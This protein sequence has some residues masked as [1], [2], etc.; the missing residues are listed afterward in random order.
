MDLSKIGL[1]IKELRKENK[2]S[3]Q[4]LADM[5]PIDRT[6]L[7]KWENGETI[8]P[9]DK[10]IKI[11]EIFKISID[12][13]ISGE[14]S[15]KE[16]INI[17]RNNLFD[18]LISQDS[19]Y[20]KIKKILFSTLIIIF[21]LIVIFLIYYFNQTYNT[22]KIFK[23]NTSSENYVV[24]NG[25]L[26]I[27]RE[28]SY[29]KIGA[30]NNEILNITIY[31]KK[32]G[33]NIVMFEGSS[34]SLIT[35]FNGYNGFINNKNIDKIKDNLYLKINEDE[36]KLYLT[37]YYNNDDLILKTWVANPDSQNSEITKINNKIP[38]KIKK[39]FKC[40]KLTCTKIIDDIQVD[41]FTENN[42]IF[43][44][45]KDNNVQYDITYNKLYF[46]N[47]NINFIVDNDEFICKSNSCIGYEKLYK[48][49]YINI[50]K[51]YI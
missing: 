30:I 18:Y 27:T 13:L 24:E 16:N 39:E 36:V 3:Q 49:Y 33:K 41:Y 6:G 44:N 37:E 35:D 31:H 20:R 15:N 19:K 38:Q 51:K 48:K 5:I 29:F 2:M 23:I 43:I 11:C 8:P 34:D 22:E 42:T 45:D 26:I 40:D 47:S 9:I 1:F 32:N 50:I 28:T 14:R 12:E 25:I 4:N 17:H 21:I 7:S 10:M 46:N